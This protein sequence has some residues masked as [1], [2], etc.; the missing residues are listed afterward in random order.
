[1]IKRM[2]VAVNCTYLQK[3]PVQV[4]PSE[5]ADKEYTLDQR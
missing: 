2:H 4:G 1:M 3:S 5:G